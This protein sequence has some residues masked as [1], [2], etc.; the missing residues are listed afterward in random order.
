MVPLQFMV[1]LMKKLTLSMIMSLLTAPWA[2]AQNPIRIYSEPVVPFQETL[3]PLSLKLGWRT[4]VPMDGRRDGVFSV[5]MVD[6]PGASSQ[7]I[8]LQTR[9]GAIMAL[10]AD[11]GVTKWRARVGN[12][13]TVSSLLGYNNESIFAVN[14]L[15]LYA[16][17]R[18]TG[19]IQWEFTLPHAPTSAPVADQDRVYLTMTGRLQAFDLPKAVDTSPGGAEKRL[20][21]IPPRPASAGPESISTGPAGSTSVLG[22][23]A[24]GMESVS[25]V[26]SRGQAVRSFGPTSSLY[27][28]SQIIPSGPQPKFIWEYLT[29]SRVEL[30]PLYT[31]N[32]VAVASYN[33]IFYVMTSEDGR[34]LYRLQA[35]PPLTA[36]LGQLG[37]IAYV[38]SE[39]FSVYA[40]DILPGHVLWR[41]S[42]GGPVKRRPIPSNDSVYVSA[43]RAGLYRLDRKTGDLIW[44]NREAD[45][46]L[47]ANAKY[48]YAT[49]QSDR[50]LILDL[51]RGNILSSFEATRD[52]VVPISNGLTDRI[53]LASNDGLIVSLHDRDYPRPVHLAFAGAPPA[54]PAKTAPGQRSARPKGEQAPP[55]PPQQPNQ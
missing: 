31:T 22:G 52:F 33:G 26:S 39:D 27:P 21:A 45:R 35:G 54:G 9:S 24:Q 7:E 51:K 55:P 12:P 6:R 2:V 20:E 53:L 18:D 13:Y 50:L 34:H 15:E 19:M 10:D 3:D 17:N 48:V 1:M 43:E 49:D 44:R 36:P 14:G 32:F 11:S 30:S 46:F 37:E 38:A 23:R 29:D 41:A 5:Q 47:A 8:L 40:L 16:L 4:Y 28:G 42:T 25:A